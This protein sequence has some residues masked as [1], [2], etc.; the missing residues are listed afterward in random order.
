MTFQ[1]NTTKVGCFHVSHTDVESLIR[2]CE[3]NLEKKN[4]VWIFTLNLENAIKFYLMKLFKVIKAEPDMVVADG[5]PVLLLVNLFKKKEFKKIKK[6]CT[7][8][9]FTQK[10][11]E[12]NFNNRIYILG[13]KHLIDL[14]KNKKNIC[15]FEGK[16]QASHENL[17]QIYKN[18]ISQ[19]E[20]CLLLIAL[21]GHKAIRV[22]DFMKNTVNSSVSI[23]VGG[24][25]DFLTGDQKRAPLFIQRI[26]LEW[27]WRFLLNPPRMFFRYFV[28]SP[29]SFAWL[30]TSTLLSRLHDK[31]KTHLNHV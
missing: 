5:W 24:S 27:F 29:L 30:L 16:I 12:K 21:S 23:G 28:V 25:L 10:V 4:K 9:D 17:S 20:P 2:Y 6:R 31:Y 3:E 7:G 26:N 1:N 19:H 11:L 14:V 13:G 8:A 15:F 18:Q 22:G